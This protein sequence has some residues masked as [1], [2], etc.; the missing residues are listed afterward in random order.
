MYVF[1]RISGWGRRRGAAST[2]VEQKARSLLPQSDLPAIAYYM[3]EY[4]AR[5]LTPDSFLTVIR[6][7][8]DTPQK[9]STPHTYYVSKCSFHHLKCLC[10]KTNILLDKTQ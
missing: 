4:A 8:L 10:G 6:D 3:E 7:L 9:V 1:N 5:R 2:A